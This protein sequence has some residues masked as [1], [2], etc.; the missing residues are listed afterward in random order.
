M[1]GICLAG[2]HSESYHFKNDVQIKADYEYKL[3]MK[4]ILNGTDKISQFWLKSLP[5]T[6]P[7]LT[8]IDI[9]QHIFYV[10]G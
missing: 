6:K 8:E 1:K 7:Q 9:L 3:T 4:N 2:K 10:I 5:Y